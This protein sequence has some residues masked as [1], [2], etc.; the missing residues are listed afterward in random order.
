MLVL[1]LPVALKLK[2]RHMLM[3]VRV[4]RTMAEYLYSAQLYVALL[5]S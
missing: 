5:D 3:A 1:P 4:I 2:I